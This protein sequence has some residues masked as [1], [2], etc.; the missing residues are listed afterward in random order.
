MGEAYI[1]AGIAIG[2]AAL[3]TGLGVGILAAKAM[4]GIARQ[5]EAQNSIRTSMI[6]AITFIEAIALYALVIGLIL[7]TK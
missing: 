6:I 7:A 2:L 4:D 5:P 3:G 1:G